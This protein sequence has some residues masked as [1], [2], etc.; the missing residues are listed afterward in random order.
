MKKFLVLI[1]I[2]CCSS[3]F[4]YAQTKSVVNFPPLIEA[5]PYVVYDHYYGTEQVVSGSELQLNHPYKLIFENKTQGET[6]ERW[7]LKVGDFFEK[8]FYYTDNILFTTPY[9]VGQSY[10]YYVYVTVETNKRTYSTTYSVFNT[11]YEQP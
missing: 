4:S 8:T 7:T 1:G 5:C 3:I 2:I 10:T 9:T 11:G 6:V